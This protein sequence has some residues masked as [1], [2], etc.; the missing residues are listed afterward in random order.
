M[1]TAIPTAEQSQAIVALK[2]T[3]NGAG[4]SDHR[5]AV[6]F[7]CEFITRIKCYSVCV[8]CCAN[9]WSF[10]F[11]FFSSLAD[12]CSSEHLPEVEIFS[13]LEEQIPKYKLR[14]DAL[15]QFGG[16]ENQVRNNI[17]YIQPGPD[18][19]RLYLYRRGGQ[20][21][22]AA[23]AQCTRLNHSTGIHVHFS[24]S[25]SSARIGLY[26]AQHCPYPREV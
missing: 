15:T 13:L 6:S 11:L 22:D 10:F 5:F 26:R 1:A 9:R 14:A 19:T 16:Y 20:R 17:L 2:K 25:F 7:H 18:R 21:L 23:Q 12:L 3:K 4:A 24:T 8:L